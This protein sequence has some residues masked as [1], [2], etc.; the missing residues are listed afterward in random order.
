MNNTS[1]DDAALQRDSEAH[2]PK[3]QWRPISTANEE[4]DD[5]PATFDS[6]QKVTLDEPARIQLPDNITPLP[7]PA[8]SKTSAEGDFVFRRNPIRINTAIVVAPTGFYG[9]VE[10]NPLRQSAPGSEDNPL[11][12]EGSLNPTPA[13]EVQFRNPLRTGQ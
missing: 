1:H 12:A 4:I 11:R 3:T 13:G 9:D 2:P 5:H 10:G 8:E 7:P 6:V